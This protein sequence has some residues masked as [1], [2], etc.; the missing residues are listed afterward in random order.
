MKTPHVMTEGAALFVP[1]S[2]DENDV[3]RAHLGSGW[4]KQH[5]VYGS[6]AAPTLW[7]DTAAILDDLHSACDVRFDIENPGE[8]ERQAREAERPS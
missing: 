8:R 5:V 2:I 3:L 6:A 1:L 7:W 4:A